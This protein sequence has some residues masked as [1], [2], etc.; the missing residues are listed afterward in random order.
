MQN[1][2]MPSLFIEEDRS[3]ATGAEEFSSEGRV[4]RQAT[5]DF[6]TSLWLLVVVGLAS[7]WI[8]TRFFPSPTRSL[9]RAVNRARRFNQERRGMVYPHPVPEM[10]DENPFA[11]ERPER[12]ASSAEG[13]P[14]SESRPL[15][16]IATDALERLARLRNEPDEKNPVA[17]YFRLEAW[18]RRY[19]AE[20]YHIKAFGVSVAEL[21]DA[22]PQASPVVD[23]AG[24]ILHIC[25]LAPFR[26][27]RPS[28]TE[29]HRL[30]DLAKA[31]VLNDVS[32]NS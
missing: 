15:D 20:R 4:P 32:P 1:V 31:M 2:G 3:L 7:W 8:G 17:D 29:L 13:A 19:L 5:G 27:F 23:Y 16:L 25:G 21:L 12:G 6:M 11:P 14:S 9:R 28:R 24:E 26:R 10:Q 18:V 22:L 30:Y